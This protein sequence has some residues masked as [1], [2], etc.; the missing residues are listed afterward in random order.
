M[1]IATSTSTGTD[2]APRG[3][4]VGLCRDE[5]GGRGASHSQACAGGGGGGVAPPPALINHCQS[6][7]YTTARTAAGPAPQPP[8]TA[9][10]AAP[11]PSLQPPPPSSSTAP[12]IAQHVHRALLDDTGRTVVTW[13][14]IQNRLSPT[15]KPTPFRALPFNARPQRTPPTDLH[16]TSSRALLPPDHPPLSVGVPLHRV[17]PRERRFRFG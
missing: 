5:D 14:C 11:E 12:P 10:A 17:P 13:R 2:H 7:R 15:G 1:R 9:A 3:P 4:A 16:M 6:N 8:V